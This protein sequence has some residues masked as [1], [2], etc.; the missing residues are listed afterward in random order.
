VA[1]KGKKT[2]LK[3]NNQPAVC[4]ITAI[5]SAT[6]NGQKEGRKKF[7]AKQSTGLYVAAW[8]DNDGNG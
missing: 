7:Q 6:A 3:I 1:T 8:G 5:V 2:S 4:C